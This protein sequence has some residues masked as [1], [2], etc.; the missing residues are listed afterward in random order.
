MSRSRRPRLPAIV[1]KGGVRLRDTIVL[2]LA[3]FCS[4][5]ALDVRVLNDIRIDCSKFL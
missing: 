4:M 1:L 3:L 5:L 2:M